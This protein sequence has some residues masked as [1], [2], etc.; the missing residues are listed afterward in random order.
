MGGTPPSDAHRSSL[1]GAPLLPKALCS[2]A[3]RPGSPAHIPSPVGM[4]GC[5]RAQAPHRLLPPLGEGL[6]APAMASSHPVPPAALAP[7]PALLFSAPHAL[8]LGANTIS[9]C[10]LG[11]L[12]S[13]GSR[14]KLRPARGGN[15]WVVTRLLR[16]CLWSC[17]PSAAQLSPG[18]LSHSC[19]EPS[20]HAGAHH[21]W[22]H[23]EMLGHQEPVI[24]GSVQH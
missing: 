15:Y 21:Y 18:L 8:V 17:R 12:G 6:S 4:T 14:M 2:Q 13:H 24:F 20:A 22:R 11:P 1:C 19:P 9:R 23:M 10:F 3:A 5:G 7:C 16:V